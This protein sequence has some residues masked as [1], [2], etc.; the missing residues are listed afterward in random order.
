MKLITLFMFIICPLVLVC[1]SIYAITTSKVMAVINLIILGLVC[2]IT[3][4]LLWIDLSID[5]PKKDKVIKDY[6]PE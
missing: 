1:N 4:Y 6:S 3:G 5:K 2:I